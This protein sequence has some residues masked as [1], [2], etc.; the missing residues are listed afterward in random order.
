MR[1]AV[2]A[3]KACGEKF[4]PTRSFQKACSPPC[5]IE[6]VRD[7]QEKKKRN[8][9]RRRKQGLKT[10]ADYMKEAQ[11]EFN[12]YIRERD[13]ALPCISFGRHHKGQYHA[14]HYLTTKAHPEMRFSEYNCHKQCAPCN[15]HKS[16]DIVNY[17]KNLLLR[18]GEKALAWVEGPH[19]I[20]HWSIDDLKD[21]KLYYRKKRKQLEKE[22]YHRG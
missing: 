20:Q 1:R 19:Y 17:R 8:E 3:C 9:T 21:I 10:K 4:T 7:Q 2:K 18:I 12:S 22:R 16:G 6:I 11:R 15:N 14:G 5:A 13:K